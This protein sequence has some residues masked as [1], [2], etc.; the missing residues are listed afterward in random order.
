MKLKRKVTLRLE[1][2]VKDVVKDWL[3]K[4]GAWHF[5]PVSNGMGKHGVHDHIACVPVVIT[6]AM[7]G[8]TVGVFVSIEAKAPG[9]RGQEDRGMSSH[10]ADNLTD[11][12]KS[13]GKAVV[14]DGYEDLQALHKELFNEEIEI[15]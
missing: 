2:D 14:C 10:Q 9:R 8:Q 3:N 5:M 1:A 15:A 13:S 7:V 12:R 4:L 11:I 6:P